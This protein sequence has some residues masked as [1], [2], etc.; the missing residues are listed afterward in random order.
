MEGST[1]ESKTQ[2]WIKFLKEDWFQYHVKRYFK[3]ITELG[4]DTGKEYTEEQKRGM[5]NCYIPAYDN[6]MRDR[7]YDNANG[8][9]VPHEPTVQAYTTCFIEELGKHMETME[10]YYLLCPHCKE[11]SVIFSVNRRAE[12]R[13]D[14]LGCEHMQWYSSE[15]Q[16][17]PLIY[18]ASEME[19]LTSDSENLGE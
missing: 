16:E 5:A 1:L 15:D 10:S 2:P 17:P 8:R 18:T 19:Q 12:C 7:E 11:T 14:L 3:I 4:V 9:R 6:M 13:I